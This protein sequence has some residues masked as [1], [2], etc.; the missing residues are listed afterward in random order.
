VKDDWKADGYVFNRLT[1]YCGKWIHHTDWYPDKKLRLFD[2]RKGLWTGNSIHELYT[3][4]P[5]YRKVFLKGDLLHYSFP[6]I[7]HHL[8]VVKKFTTIAAAENYQSGKNI[9]LFYILIKPLWKFVKS[10]FIRLGFLDGY[11]GYVIAKISAHA[12]F[13]KYI[14]LRELYKNISP[15]D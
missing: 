5:G 8:D 14:K 4:Q 1:N 15:V 3:L 10:Y 6:S 2:K 12:T 13:I 11:Y 9:N 7:D